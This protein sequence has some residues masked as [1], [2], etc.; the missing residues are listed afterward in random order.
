[1]KF[2][3]RTFSIL[4]LLLFAVGVGFLIAFP[5]YADLTLYRSQLNSYNIAHS[6]TLQ[7]FTRISPLTYDSYQVDYA[8]ASSMEYIDPAL[9]LKYMNEGEVTLDLEK[10]GTTISV[11]SVNI[12]AAI[13]DGENAETMMEGP[14]RFPLSGAPG[15]RSNMVIFGHRFAELPPSTNTFFNLDKVK[16]GDKIRVEQDGGISY[17]YTVVSVQVVEKNDRTVLQDYGDHRIT[18]MTCTPLWTSEKRLAVV[19]ILDRT[20]RRI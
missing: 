1:M 12:Q 6:F 18:L 20:Y 14:W 11:D 13:Q 2:L 4:L 10:R 8:S 3:L 7:L 9:L 16:I 5:N 17:N 15:E 19:G